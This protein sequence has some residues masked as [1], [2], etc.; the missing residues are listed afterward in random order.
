MGGE[1]AK[2]DGES[3]F[4]GAENEDGGLPGHVGGDAVHSAQSSSNFNARGWSTFD[5]TADR[6]IW[7]FH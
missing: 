1:T 5:V 4:A 2:D 7:C 6:S 3:Q